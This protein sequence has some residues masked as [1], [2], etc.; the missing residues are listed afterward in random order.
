MTPLLPFSTSIIL[1]SSWLG[2][3]S[4][5]FVTALIYYWLE[6]TVQDW[7]SVWDILQAFISM[8]GISYTT[9]PYRSFSAVETFYALPVHP[10]LPLPLWLMAKLDLFSVC[11]YFPPFTI[12]MVLLCLNS[13]I[14]DNYMTTILFGG[15]FFYLETHVSSTWFHS[16]I[17]PLFLLLT[18]AYCIA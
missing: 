9:V 15:D 3:F 6:S 5:I 12:S 18:S 7:L 13:H 2:L 8:C 4:S 1:V 10:S 11:F 17:G 16:L 14:V